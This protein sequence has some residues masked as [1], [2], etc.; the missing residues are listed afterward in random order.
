MRGFPLLALF[1]VARFETLAL[2]LTMFIL[3]TPGERHR[4]SVPCEPGEATS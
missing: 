1:E 4:V 2:T 3:E